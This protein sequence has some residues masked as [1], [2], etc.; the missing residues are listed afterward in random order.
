M[1]KIKG[2]REFKKRLDNLKG[3]KTRKQVVAALYSIGQNIEIDAEISI[4]AGAISGKGHV[5]SAPG[6]PPNADTRHLDTN[7]ETRIVGHHPPTVVV[8]SLAEYSAALEFGTS[9]MVERPFM[10][11]ALAKNRKDVKKRVSTAIRSE[12]Q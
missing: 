4:T 6:K 5:P 10:R 3:Q 8:E 2:V 9:V 1:A 12:S 11:P 7:I